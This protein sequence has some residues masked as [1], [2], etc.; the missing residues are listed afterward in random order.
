VQHYFG[1]SSGDF[2]STSWGSWIIKSLQS[3]RILIKLNAFGVRQL[4]N[5]QVDFTLTASDFVPGY[6]VNYSALSSLFVNS[7][8]ES[9]S[10][11][12]PRYEFPVYAYPKACAY[13]VKGIC[14]FN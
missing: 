1:S 2:C 14:E 11:S 10:Y 5:G 4:N 8:G 6:F 3:V 7:L 13:Q 9:F 12:S